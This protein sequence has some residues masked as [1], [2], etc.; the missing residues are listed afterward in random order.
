MNWD[1][2]KPNETVP[3]VFVLNMDFIEISKVARKSHPGEYQKK[4][5]VLQRRIEGIFTRDKRCYLDK[6]S[7]DGLVVLFKDK[8]DYADDLIKKA[9]RVMDLI[10]GANKKPV[11]PNP[12]GI[13]IGINIGNIKFNKEI[14]KIVGSTMNKAGHL[15][16]HCPGDGGI[17]VRGKVENHI[18]EKKLW[19]GFFIKTVYI[20]GESSICY[21]YPLH[22]ETE[23]PPVIGCEERVTVNVAE[24]YGE[25]ALTE[26][27][28]SY[29]AA[30]LKWVGQAKEVT[31][32]GI[33][34]VWLYL[35]IGKALHGK[36]SKLVYTSPTSGDIVVFDNLSY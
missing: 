14:G 20:K 23:V 5:N 16:K 25:K 27:R 24:L 30:A 11:F 2:L 7:G 6:W 4:L 19:V 3:D 9:I 1:S 32:T 36:V 18:N 15:Q 12:I 28:D 17:L 22:P 31:L 13:R 33:G 8:D 21:Y 26:K 35:L 10:K 29:I 34:P